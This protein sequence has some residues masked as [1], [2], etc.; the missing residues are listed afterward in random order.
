[1]AFGEKGSQTLHLVQRENSP[2][3]C[4]LIHFTQSAGKGCSLVGH[5]AERESR[6]KA[7]INAS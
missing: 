1:M 5:V 2:P 6:C 3:D 4:F 7:E